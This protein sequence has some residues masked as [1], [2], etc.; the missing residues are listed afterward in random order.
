MPDPL[1]TDMVQNAAPA[2]QTLVSNTNPPTT[3]PA[4][5]SPTTNASATAASPGTTLP[6]ASQAATQPPST[7]SPASTVTP[8][9]Q[10]TVSN[11]TPNLS[12]PPPQT[13]NVP[14]PQLPPNSTVPEGQPNASH[15]AVQRAGVTN[16]VAI[17]LAG[18]PRYRTAVDPET[19]AVTRTQV[20]LSKRDVGLAIAF[21]ALSGALA[22]YGVKPGPGAIG[23]AG[24]A[25][26]QEGQQETAAKQKQDADQAA[27]AKAD[28]D[29]QTAVLAK[30]AA[31]YE[32][33]SRT[34]LNTS[35]VEQRGADAI[36]KLVAINRQ[37]GVLD[38]DAINVLNNGQPMTQDELNDAMR[39]GAIDPT[40]QLGPI[41]GREEITGADGSKRWQ[42]THLIIKDGSAPVTL[43]QADWDRYAAAGVP[44][45]TKG[46]QIGGNTQVKLSMVQRANEIVASHHLADLRL[47]DLRTTLDGT[48]L[49]DKVPS[50]I[51]WTQPGT[52]TA[53]QR[54]QKYVSH[55]ADNLAD[56]YLA[57]QA[58]GTAKRDPKTGEMAPNPDAKYADT[59]ATALGGW[60]VL[61]AA[62]N[63]LLAN[64]ADAAK[65]SIIDTA[66]KANAVLASPKRFTADQVSAARGFNA[67]TAQQGERKTAEDARAHAVATGAD[68]EAMYRFGRNPVTGKVLNLDNAAPAMLVDSSGNV[69][70]QD[71]IST[72]K[73]TAAQRQTG[74]TARQ[75]L[76]I[77]ADLRQAIAANPALAGPLSGRSKS[78]LAK[79]GLGDAQA[80]KFLDDVS[81][82]QTA[83]T[84]MHSGRF[85]N[86]ILDKMSSLIQPG[87]NDGQFSGALD[88]ITGVAGR[89]ADEDRLTTVASYR[90]QQQQPQQGQPA[91]ASQPNARTPNTQTPRV[92]PKGATPGR[93]RAGNIVGYRLPNGQTVSF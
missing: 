89:Y 41:A 36:D 4:T 39:K 18:G 67:L 78:G 66:D 63:Q 28:A 90:S 79:L 50:T 8:A 20:P 32:A 93:D 57:L 10:D 44:G 51:D 88:S 37:S 29:N 54:Y 52:E 65:Y 74:D 45:F 11:R 87:M 17:A 69:I 43:S 84:K 85:S 15:P 86:A 77:A 61:E 27:A 75:V 76:S 81:F 34:L 13:P 72:Y 53:M 16:S 19:G 83:A 56:P 33:N 59:V 58:M 1:Q 12:T 71:L 80:Q 9:T 55:N 35:E 91:N 38:T 6:V 26:L 70:P 47:A 48:P 31:I 7:A 73:P 14:N 92:V 25:G 49:A 21:Q 40:A 23:R 42:A 5:A 62:H 24:F 68:V 64:K 82:L 46:T 2:S 22:G 3:A 60:P 30:R